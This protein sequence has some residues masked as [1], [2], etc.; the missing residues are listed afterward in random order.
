MKAAE[1]N[2]I[3]AQGA[4]LQLQLIVEPGT[5][6]GAARATGVRSSRELRHE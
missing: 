1:S 4:V 3:R 2:Q 6:S 5:A